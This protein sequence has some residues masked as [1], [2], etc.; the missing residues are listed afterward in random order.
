VQ[1]WRWK[2]NLKVVLY[3]DP[4]DQIQVKLGGKCFSPLSCLVS[5]I[6]SNL[7]TMT[8]HGKTVSN[9][10]S[11][12]ALVVL[13]SPMQG[14]ALI[15][16][17]NLVWPKCYSMCS[18]FLQWDGLLAFLMEHIHWKVCCW[19]R[20]HQDQALSTKEIDLPQRDRGQGIRDNK[21]ETG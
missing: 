6:P 19:H 3:L 11:C 10:D 18:L 7:K 15:F 5:P 9:Q 14:L 4:V 8:G 12:R 1:I 17:N 20:T 16:F 21:Q 13:P 2:D